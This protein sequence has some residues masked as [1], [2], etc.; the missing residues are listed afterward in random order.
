MLRLYSVQAQHDDS[1]KVETQRGK[2]LARLLPYNNP[3]LH[4]GY[5]AS[6]KDVRQ[7]KKLDDFQKD[8]M[9]RIS[10]IYKKHISAN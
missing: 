3:L 4:K 1:I 10:D 7:T 9:G 8:V 5:E 6:R 2:S